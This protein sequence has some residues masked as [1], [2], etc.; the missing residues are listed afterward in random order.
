MPVPDS[1]PVP[2]S[3]PDLSRATREGLFGHYACGWKNP[4]DS[5]PV[6][7]PFVSSHTRLA[8]VHLGKK[9]SLA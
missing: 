8:E 2:D 4:P 3:N 5:I 7:T 1:K 9:G 6:D